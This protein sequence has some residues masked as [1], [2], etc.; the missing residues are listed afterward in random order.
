MHEYR[1]TLQAEKKTD[2][3]CSR[4]RNSQCLANYVTRITVRLWYFHEKKHKV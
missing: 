4:D 1:V 2:E 3:E